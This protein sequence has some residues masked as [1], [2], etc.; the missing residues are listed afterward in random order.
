MNRRKTTGRHL[1]P[2]MLART[3]KLKGGSV[4]VGYYYNGL[5]NGKRKE[6]PLGTDLAEAKR[7]WAELDCK[8][9]PV[10]AGT[11]EVVFARYEKE[12]LPTKAPR[13]QIDNLDQLARLR[14]VFAS[15]PIDAV[16]PQHIARYRDA[17]MTKARTLADGTVQ[18]ARRATVAANRELALFS[19]I[20]NKAREWGYTA[21]TNPCAGV[22]KNKET[23]RDFYADDEVWQAVRSVAVQELQDA[24][25]LAY[26]TGQRPA[27][28]L[29]HTWQSITDE[30]LL[31]R[32]GKTKKFLRVQF[33][34]DGARNELG[35]LIDKIKARKVR[36]LHLLMTAGGLRL[37]KHTLRTRFEAARAL[38]AEQSRAAGNT[39]LAERIEEF[40]FRDSRPKAASEIELLSDASALLGHSDQQITKTVYRRVG[41]KV[42]PTR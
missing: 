40:Q 41:Q 12:I 27:D 7:K 20:W 11:L 42:K 16:T 5:K 28:V 29:K 22:S 19:H 34:T 30:A 37:N 32:Q 9:V 24:M 4:W 14:S 23:P 18:P 35:R 33:E 2:R 25:D 31:V 39:I 15:A 17:R 36:G 10:E 26:L 8:A 1:P 3:R 6:T 13:T 38:A 21:K